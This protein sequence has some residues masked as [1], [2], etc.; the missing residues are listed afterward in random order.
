MVVGVILPGCLGWCRLVLLGV[1]VPA[2]RREGISGSSWDF[3]GNITSC[4]QPVRDER[5]TLVCSRKVF[6]DTYPPHLLSFPPPDA[7]P[8]PI[9]KCVCCDRATI[10]SCRSERARVP[11]SARKRKKAK[12]EGKQ[13]VCA[14]VPHG[15]SQPAR[16]VC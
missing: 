1:S 5:N 7:N 6:V 10:V 16:V 12:R 13:G 14:D 8:P 15:K 2:C 4:E 11:L 3:F 9:S